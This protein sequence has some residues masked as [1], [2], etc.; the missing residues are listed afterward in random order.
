VAARH[1]ADAAAAAATRA[2]RSTRSPVSAALGVCPYAAAHPDECNVR[3]NAQIAATPEPTSSG[4]SGLSTGAI[5]G[6]LFGVIGVAILGIIIIIIIVYTYRSK[7]SSNSSSASASGKKAKQ[8]A[9]SAKA[10][11]A[12]AMAGKAGAAATAS[13]GTRAGY[14]ATGVTPSD[15][16][17]R[18]VTTGQPG[19]AGGR[20]VEVQPVAATPQRRM[21]FGFEDE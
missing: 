19:A 11:A 9:A 10:S 14:S 1:V 5:L 4:G 16:R 13:A 12:S 8:T 15:V 17:Y 3:L 20:P 2:R 6:I 18:G 7:N 21:V